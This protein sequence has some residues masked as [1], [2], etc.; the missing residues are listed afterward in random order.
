MSYHKFDAEGNTQVYS[1]RLE[2]DGWRIYQTSDWEHRWE[3]GGGGPV[4]ALVRWEPSA[5]RMALSQSWSHWLHGSGT[6]R[7][8]PER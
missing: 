3:F 5:S 8:D 7:L 2:D 6:W 4:P 1:A